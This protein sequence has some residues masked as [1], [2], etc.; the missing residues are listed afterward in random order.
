MTGGVD[1][2]L[3]GSTTF[4]PQVSSED[5]AAK[6]NLVAHTT[7]SRPSGRPKPHPALSAIDRAMTSWP[8]S[9]S[10]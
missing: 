2:N 1:S 5:V 9:R 4:S 10:R 7:R 8:M 6:A 3:L